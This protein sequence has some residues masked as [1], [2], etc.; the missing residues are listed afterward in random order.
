MLADGGTG[1]VSFEIDGVRKDVGLMLEA[2]RTA[3]FRDDLLRT[4]LGLVDD[5]ADAG[6]GDRD[7]AAV[8]AALAAPQ[9]Q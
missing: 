9:T 2:A 5:V 8:W 4:V 3:R 1:P 6:H 7:M